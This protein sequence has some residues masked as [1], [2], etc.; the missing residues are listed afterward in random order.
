[1]TIISVGYRRIIMNII[2]SFNVLLWLFILYFF[3]G[4]QKIDFKDKKVVLIISILF[5][6]EYIYINLTE[7]NY[8]SFIPFF[9]FVSMTFLINYLWYLLYK[10]KDIL[11]QNNIKLD[12]EPIAWPLFIY[13]IFSINKKIKYKELESIIFKIKLIPLLM[14]VII[15]NFVIFTFR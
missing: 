12:Y 3:F 13:N 11:E 2:S 9:T 5:A 14:L 10:S 1:M 7:Y 4:K 15:L 8:I 6:L